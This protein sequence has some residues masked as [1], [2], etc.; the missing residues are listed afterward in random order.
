MYMNDV[1][2]G[3][4]D[5]TDH[6]R[7]NGRGCQS[8]EGTNSENLDAAIESLS[9]SAVII[10]NHNCDVSEFLQLTTKISQMGFD[11]APVRRVEL[12]NLKHF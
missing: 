6:S 11:S 9:G 8:T 5:R 3:R 12:S 4:M 7:A 10:G 2:F 1:G